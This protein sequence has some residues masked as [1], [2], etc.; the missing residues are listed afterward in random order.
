MALVQFSNDNGFAATLNVNGA[1][2]TSS[3][4]PFFRSMGTNGRSCGSC[5][6]PKESWTITPAGVKA[7]FDDTDGL[8]PIFRPNDG[9]VSPTADVST[10][11]ARRSAYAMLLTKGLIR[12]GIGIPPS[13]E[14][15]LV[16]VD[17]PYGYA[18]ASELSLFRRP[19]PATNLR[20][21][22]ATMWDGRESTP[23]ADSLRGPNDTD[24]D[25]SNQSNDATL[26]HAQASSPVPPAVRAEI[27]RFELGLFTAQSSTRITGSL[28]E[29][30]AQGGVGA[31]STQLNYFG[32]NDVVA[33]DSQTG[34]PFDAHGMTMFTAWA[35][36]TGPKSAAREAIA[37]GE[38]LFNTRA[39]AIEG[40]RG[41]NDA[42][43]IPTLT[44]T[45]TTCHDAPNVGNHSVRLPLD[46][47]LTDAARRT[48]DMPLYTL[49]KRQVDA[50]GAP[51][52]GTCDA[53]VPR[54]QT[55]DPGR[56][57]I[58]GKWKD[59]ATFKGPILRGLSGRAPYFH[60]GSAA[61]LSDVVEFYEGRFALGLTAAEK[62]DLV[63]FLGA[64]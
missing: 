19:L 43:G 7:R 63:A 6:V 25:L 29:D 60:N 24:T 57:L 61:T 41:V 15:E 38:E 40:V 14:L 2:D 53:S 16:A 42:L 48:R 47:G 31:L 5:H 9:S 59:V 17:D 52:A 36:A 26:G 39:I 49:C 20:L 22:T 64:L 55:T 11:K 4:N 35:S 32:I 18:S 21:L 10:A 56:A 45:C 3:T 62:A 44:G 12:V 50:N 58:S 33:G 37:R 28:D 8:D 34:M 23:I 30:G 54:I 27:V 46:L 1:I 13:G 51:I